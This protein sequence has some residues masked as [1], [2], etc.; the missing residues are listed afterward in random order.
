M[1]S[2]H[3]FLLLEKAFLS[4]FVC[5]CVCVC[6]SVSVSVCEREKKVCR[7]PNGQ[8]NDI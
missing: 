6:V 8:M 7:S 4:D 1:N 5:V 3:V 2:K